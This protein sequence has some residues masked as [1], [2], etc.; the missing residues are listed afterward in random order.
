MMSA[1]N[2]P[3]DVRP[4]AWEQLEEDRPMPLLARRRVIGR[5]AMISRVTLEKGCFVPTHAHVNEQITCV[6]EGRLRMRLGAEGD[7]ARREVI[8]G[9]GEV[10]L[11]PS[12]VPHDAE[13]LERTVVLDVFSPPS[14]TTGI[15]RPRA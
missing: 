4:V 1:T 14:A 3:K 7:P 9:P 11:L 10:L 2:D 12:D 13:A 8:V 5:Q 6:L 15:D